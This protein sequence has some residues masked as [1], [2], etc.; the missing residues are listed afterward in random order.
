MQGADLEV[1]MT[2]YWPAFLGYFDMIP[3]LFANALASEDWRIGLALLAIPLVGAILSRS[4][5]AVLAV[6]T[7]LLAA[8]FAARTGSPIGAL[9]GYS[10]ALV[11]IFLGLI[12]QARQQRIRALSHELAQMRIEM[13]GFLNGIE[14]RSR[15]LDEHSARMA[16]KRATSTPAG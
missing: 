5:F 3:T 12:D 6:G 9:A 8:L 16:E 2:E 7:T 14:K 13:N 4:G 1:V 15:L 11:A 10:T